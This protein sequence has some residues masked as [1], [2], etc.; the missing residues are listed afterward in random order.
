MAIPAVLI[1][2]IKAR[3]II[4]FLIAIV[5]GLI[6]SMV[7]WPQWWRKY[8][9]KKKDA[10]ESALKKGLVP[11]VAQKTFNIWLLI[12][13]ILVLICGIIIGSMLGFK[14]A[15]DH[16]PQPVLATSCIEYNQCS[17]INCSELMTS[18][19]P[20]CV[21]S[22]CGDPNYNGAVRIEIPYLTR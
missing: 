22:Y 10:R 6:F 8:Y 5:L 1:F 9:Q 17:Q 13:I 18:G 15:V 21:C 4:W 12:A 14:Q 11:K 7:M 2:G 19:C 3:T 16:I 20:G